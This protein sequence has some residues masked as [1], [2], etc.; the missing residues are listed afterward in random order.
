MG[1]V[2]ESALSLRF[3][4]D[5]LDPQEVSNLLGA[6]PTT[7]YR[8]GDVRTRTRSD[9]VVVRT[10]PDGSEWIRKYGMWKLKAAR[11]E[12]ADLDAQIYEI[13]GQLTDDLAVWRDLTSRFK[14]DVFV[15]LF[16]KIFNDGISISPNALQIV[17]SRGLEVDFDIYCEREG[18]G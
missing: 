2:G 16:V 18:V 5:D 11:Q 8:K 12:P 4:G 10:L 13:F 14:A 9:D 6:Q 7:S 15:G 3:F 1:T 17:A